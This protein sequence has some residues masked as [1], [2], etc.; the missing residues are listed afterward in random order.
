MYKSTTK[1]DAKIVQ[2]DEFNKIINYCKIPIVVIG[3]INENTIP[4]FKK[5]SYFWLYD[6]QTNIGKRKHNRVNKEIKKY[7]FVK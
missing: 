5:K 4:N 6:D 2:Q 1:K 7:Y 3:G